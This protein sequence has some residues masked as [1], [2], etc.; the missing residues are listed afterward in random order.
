[1]QIM[2]LP[3]MLA[4]PSDALWVSSTWVMQWEA[5]IAIFQSTHPAKKIHF[6]T[7]A[8]SLGI[9]SKHCMGKDCIRI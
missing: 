5:Y 4:L 2:N 7:L 1:M 3:S 9:C 6:H 8:D